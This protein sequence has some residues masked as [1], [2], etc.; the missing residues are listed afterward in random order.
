LLSKKILSRRSLAG[1]FHYGDLSFTLLERSRRKQA[2]YAHDRN[3]LA[4]RPPSSIHRRLR[5]RAHPCSTGPNPLAIGFFLSF[6]FRNVG[7]E[8]R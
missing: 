6:A 3:S 5:S 1:G 7:I 4:P 2:S 8:L